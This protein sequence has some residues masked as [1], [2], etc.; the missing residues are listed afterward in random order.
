MFSFGLNLYSQIN[1]EKVKL[2]LV[3]E[4]GQIGSQYF[5]DFVEADEIEKGESKED[6][7]IRINR[8]LGGKLKQGLHSGTKKLRFGDF[9]DTAYTV[10][11]SFSRSNEDGSN[12]SFAFKLVN[13][14]TGETSR[15]YKSDRGGRFGSRLNLLGDCLIGVGKKAAPEIEKVILKR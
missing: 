5:D 13:N 2:I 1:V 11:V 6:A 10:T 4:D 15:I 7:I 12:A 9:D 8:S 14:E 3:M